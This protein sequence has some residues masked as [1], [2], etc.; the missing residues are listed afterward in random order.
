MMPVRLGLALG[1]AFAVLAAMPQSQAATQRIG[2]LSNNTSEAAASYVAAFREGLRAQGLVEGRDVTIEFR[3]ANRRFTELPAL[4]REL[5]AMKVDVI[6]AHVTEPSLAAHAATR[7]IPIVIVGVGDPIG[8]GLVTNL[9]RPGGNVTGSAG[10]TVETAGK[11]VALLKEAVPGLKR[12]GVLWNPA[13][14]TYQRQLLREVQAAARELA[15]EAR[16]YPMTDLEAIEQSFQAMGKDRVGGVVALSDP[17][18]VAHG[19]RIAALARAARLPSIGGLPPYA[20]WGGLVAYGP[21]FVALSRD[22]ADPVARILRGAKPGDLAV[23]RPSRFE[24]VVNAKTAKAIGA[25]IPP[26]LQLRADR[27]I[28]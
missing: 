23:S 21:D 16:T 19:Q 25:T 1:L 22:A 18:L 26:A 8:V 9:S 2:F 24:F 10:M 28:E 13:N 4:A 27:V 11:T 12:V 17:A 20:D 7:T 15:I 14:A 5:V 3:Y 6:V